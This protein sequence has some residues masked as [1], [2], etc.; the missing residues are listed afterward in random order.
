MPVPA[1]ESAWWGSLLWLVGL[2]AV[3]F[4]FAWLSGTRL[5]IRRTW[6]IP[7]L[8]AV[9]VG[10][11]LGY[12]EWLG[13]SFTQVASTR[14]GWGLLAAVA[15]AMLLA[16]PMSH[17][18][19]TRHVRGRQLRWELFWE[20]GVYGCTEGVLLSALP[21]FMTWQLVHALGWQGAAG[22]IA[23]WSLPVLAAATV[24]VVHHLGYWSCRN[25]ILIPI[26][27]GLTVLTI[28]FLITASWIAPALGHVLVHAEATV[29]GTEMPPH[30]R[31]AAGG[32]TQPSNFVAATH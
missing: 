28:G 19:V 15:A 17:Q 6:Y 3:T 10:L 31:P 4:V 25:Q 32:A 12:L 30:P 24:V 27:L 14:W 18:P 2:A 22:G 7:L 29:H 21:P 9:T 8:F 26:T 20:G 13:V 16:K 23:R 1:Q 5:G 11:T